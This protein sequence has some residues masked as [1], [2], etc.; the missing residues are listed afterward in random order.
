MDL[1]A[2]SY[3]KINHIDFQIGNERKREFRAA[4]IRF[5]LHKLIARPRSGFYLHKLSV[6]AILKKAT[7]DM[8]LFV[9]TPIFKFRPTCDRFRYWVS[10]GK[11]LG[12]FPAARAKWSRNPI[13]R[14]AYR[15]NFLLG[16]QT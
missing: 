12:K 7:D 10:H 5:Y 1:E 3:L 8:A 11:L 15:Y 9:A 4:E 14:T 6:G 16:T 2:I 13:K